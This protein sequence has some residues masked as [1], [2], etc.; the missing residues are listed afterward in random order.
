MLAQQTWP[1]AVYWLFFDDIGKNKSAQ[2]QHIFELRGVTLYYHFNFVITFLYQRLPLIKKSM[3]FSFYSIWI[4]V[5]VIIFRIV[6]T[7]Y[8]NAIYIDIIKIKAVSNDLPVA[9]YPAR[10]LTSPYKSD[11]RTYEHT[12]IMQSFLRRYMFLSFINTQDLNKI[13]LHL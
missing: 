12:S 13:I 11:N 8:K 7:Y 4:T 1:V 10:S 6:S 9:P 5:T 3:L 2:A